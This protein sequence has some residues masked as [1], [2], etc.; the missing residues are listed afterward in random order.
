MKRLKS[1]ILICF[2]LIL[3]T[4]TFACDKSN[5][6]VLVESI[7]LSAEEITLRPDEIYDLT[8]TV[9]PANSENKQI[10]YILTDSSCVSLIIDSE[11]SYKAQIVANSTIV[12]PVSTYLQVVTVDETIRSNTLKINVL[13]NKITLPSPQN[14]G[15]DN[16]NQEIFWDNIESAS[17][18]EVKINIEGEEPQVVQSVLNKVKIDD[19]YDK[20]ISVEVKSLGDDVIYINSN[21]SQTSFK[22]IQLQEPQNLSNENEYIKFKKVENAK[23]YNIFVYANE[24]KDNADYTFNVLDSNY[25]E[26]VGFKI[27]QLKTEGITFYVKVQS[28]PFTRI[29]VTSYASKIENSIK[30]YKFATP[31]TVNENFK[32][33]YNTN[34]ISWKTVANAS[35]YKIVR[36]G[37]GEAKVYDFDASEN[38]FVI[39]TEDDKLDAG[40]YYYTLT[41]LGNSVD[42][43]NSNA[44][45]N[46]QIEKLSSPNLK[47]EQGILKWDSVNNASGYLLRIDGGLFTQLSSNINFYEL[48]DSYEA[49]QYA[50]EI[51][52]VGNGENSITSEIGDKFYAIKL[53]EPNKAILNNNK[54]LKIT[55]NSYVDSMSVYLTYN[56][57]LPIELNRELTLDETD[58]NNIIKYLEL[59][60]ENGSYLVNGVERYF[61]GGNYSVYAR[62][63]KEGYF[64][65]NP[66][67]LFNFSKLNNDQSI[68]IANGQLNLNIPTTVNKTEIYLNDINV[69]YENNKFYRVSDNSEVKI[70]AG[71]DYFINLKYFPN[72][73]ENIVISNKTSSFTFSKFEPID[74]F[75]VENG[76]IKFAPTNVVN[77]RFEVKINDNVQTYSSLNNIKLDDDTI[78]EI[79]MYLFGGN[80]KLNSDKS[81]IIKVKLIKN[82]T[83]LKLNGDIFSF[84]PVQLSSGYNVNIKLNESGQSG[85]IVKNIGSN[86]NFSLSELIKE[87]FQNNVYNSLTNPLEIHVAYLGGTL[88]DPANNENLI[89]GLNRNLYSNSENK[90]NSI[91]VKILPSPTNLRATKLYDMVNATKID[92]NELYFDCYVGSSVFELKYNNNYKMLT[93]QDLTI[94]D[95]KND[96][97]TYKIDTSFLPSGTY[98]FEFRAVSALEV[99]TDGSED[100]IYNID[101]LDVVTLQDI[102]KIESID[103]LEIVKTGNSEIIKI[104]DTDT[105]YAYL[106]TINGKTIYDDILEE[107]TDLNGLIQKLLDNPLNAMDYINSF[108]SKERSLPSSYKGTFNINCFKIAVPSALEYLTSA[109]VAI[110]SNALVNSI[111]VTRLSAPVYSLVNGELQ[112]RAVDNAEKYLIYNTKTESNKTVIDYNNLIAEVSSG[113]YNFDV[114]NYFYGV[115]GNYNLIMLAQTSNTNFLASNLT[116]LIKF[117]ILDIPQLKIEDGQVEWS[118]VKNTAGYY[119]EVYKNNN[120]FDTLMFNNTTLHYTAMKTSKNKVV[121]AGDYQFKIQALGALSGDTST[122]MTSLIS[123]E[124][125]AT[126][127]NTPAIAYVNAGKI[128]LTPVEHP[129]GVEY[130]GLYIN[131]SISRIDPN[132][133]IVELNSSYDAGIYNFSYFAKG[134]ESYLTSNTNKIITA[135]KLSASSKVYV[136]DGK[137][138]YNNVSAI[139]YKNIDGESTVDYKINV[140]KE[141]VI[142]SFVQTTNLYDLAIDDDIES[143]LYKIEVISLGDDYYYLNS[144]ASI[145]NNVLKLGNISNFRIEDGKLQWDN[146]G[147]LIGLGA[148]V[149]VSPNGMQLILTKDYKD[150]KFTLKNLEEEF[151]LDSSFEYGRYTVTIQNIGNVGDSVDGINYINSKTISYSRTFNNNE[152]NY[153]YKLQKLTNLNINDGINLKWT[154]PNTNLSEFL[155]NIE[156]NLNDIATNYSG[157]LKSNNSSIVFEN[158]Y[159]YVND[160]DENILVLIDDEDVVY[161][162][163]TPTYNGYTLNKFGSDGTFKV[164]VKAYGN[165]TYI[166]SDSS[167]VIEITRPSPVENLK[168]EHGRISWTGSSDANGYIITLSR[169]DLLGNINSDDEE[170]NKISQII[171]VTNQTYYNLTTVQKIYNIGVRAYSLISEN[172]T[173]TISSQMVQIFNYTFNTFDFGSGT[174]EDPYQISNEAM[175]GYIKYNNFATYILTDDINLASSFT[176]LFTQDYPFVGKLLGNNKSINNLTI[177][178]LN[179]NSLNVGLLGYISSQV[180][181]DDRAVEENVVGIFVRQTTQKTYTGLVK[182][183]TFN[184]ISINVGCFV[185]A[186]SGVNYGEIDNIKIMSGSIV[187]QSVSR[188][189][190]GASIRDIYSGSIVGENYGKISNCVTYAIIMPNEIAKTY[191][192]GI[193]AV[194]YGEILSSKVY[195]DVHGNVAGGI[196]AKNFGLIEG[197]EVCGTIII[198][199]YN[200][201]D[202]LVALGG[203]ISALNGMV[204]YDEQTDTTIYLGT[205]KNCYVNSLNIG[206]EGKGL[207]NSSKESLGDN[208]KVYMGGLVGENLGYLYNNVV[209]IELD[210]LHDNF[211]VMGKLIGYN[212]SNNCKFNYCLN[213]NL[214][215]AT[216]LKGDGQNLDSTN[217][218]VESLTD[219]NLVDIL[220]NTEYVN[221]INIIWQIEETTI[222]NIVYKNLRLKVLGN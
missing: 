35:G 215:K 184:N 121:E 131:N 211:T 166:T 45:N 207:Y 21:Y 181:V 84:D 66:S 74:S 1:F 63:Y 98:D 57:T 149:S 165:N 14:I 17:G 46:L 135:E 87:N 191:S 100:I 150:R 13:T 41:I 70:I 158:I 154:D 19:Y 94:I 179:S 141:S 43:L 201:A 130:Y 73:N 22:F 72:P 122:V 96:Y 99:D 37:V 64:T 126:K 180:I 93:S 102:V 214:G 123:D 76:E 38:T 55:T 106:L 59:D 144:D 80:S 9:L 42:Y 49:K 156:Y 112:W 97:Y 10:K 147:S 60:I 136:N 27:D 182:D 5:N 193:S 188:V 68:E 33:S 205:I 143:N 138:Y 65:S 157:V 176:S 7:T 40:V 6:K 62:N 28:V 216:L 78:Y 109:G 115:G 118:S 198:Y 95:I 192:G 134:Q 175:L 197:C 104:N 52:S 108:K 110:R 81:D 85:T 90:S 210:E 116:N 29:D 160:D 195:G 183:L 25:N 92:I 79:S 200:A 146:P 71:E 88:L 172:S 82:I 155:V 39:D 26:N 185:G 168:V 164:S 206:L 217:E 83:N 152:I 209:N 8:V 105:D 220:N 119:L 153:I 174:D 31:T 129:E 186:I 2:C 11:N 44:S 24:I 23:S 51:V 89:V 61:V 36:T 67:N 162:G 86:S 4:F 187:S 170:F 125:S 47:V 3:G 113:V 75:Y 178:N 50:F 177:N 69:S 173:Q 120:L 20:I 218:E 208:F 133:L 48:G 171:Y 137:I 142:K 219:Q 212:R 169:T 140:N 202:T 58:E 12:G 101:S 167:N 53:Y 204:E 151:I 139:N 128:N 30:I 189:D 114:Y 103:S 163:E 132:N 111:E 18:Y 56:N 194:N 34:T 213:V 203:G 221:T 190:T 107:G 159:Y 91:K 222:S 15:Y 148:N 32:F 196:T 54:T 161:N 145:L 117:T 127:L 124:I 16:L 77:A 199:N